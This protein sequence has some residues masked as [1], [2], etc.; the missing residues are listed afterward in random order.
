MLRSRSML[1]NIYATGSHRL[2]Q[3]TPPLREPGL[4]SLLPQG[5][6][7]GAAL[8]AAQSKHAG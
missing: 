3:K 7:S 2:R 1:G 5:L 4:W 8:Y 6:L